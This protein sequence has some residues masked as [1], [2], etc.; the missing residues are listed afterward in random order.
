MFNEKINTS[1]SNLKLINMKKID[2]LEHPEA[3][4]QKIIAFKKTTEQ[5][6]EDNQDDEEDYFANEVEE[7]IQYMYKYESFDH[8]VDSDDQIDQSLIIGIGEDKDKKIKNVLCCNSKADEEEKL[9][10]QIYK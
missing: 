1:I 9:I 8:D 2:Q 6:S 7:E 4:D 5:N 10:N 3:T